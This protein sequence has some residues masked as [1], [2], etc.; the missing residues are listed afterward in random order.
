MHSLH[1]RAESCGS[2]MIGVLPRGRAYKKRVDVGKRT[3]GR[4]QEMKSIGKEQF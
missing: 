3:G 1:F 2:G 4:S